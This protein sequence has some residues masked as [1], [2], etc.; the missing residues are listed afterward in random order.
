LENE[1]R[2]LHAIEQVTVGRTISF[3]HT[4]KI[5]SNIGY[6]RSDGVWVTQYDS[7][8]IVMNQE[9]KIIKWQFTKGTSL[10]QVRTI[11]EDLNSL[12]LEQG[13]GIQTVFI[14]DCC[15]LRPKL[16]SIFGHNVEVK[17]D[18]FHAIQRITRTVSK[19]HSLYHQCVLDLR[20][21]F[22]QRGDSGEKRTAETPPP[23]DIN[24]N[25]SEFCRKWE[26][27]CDSE[28]KQIWNTAT[29]SA[30][31]NLQTHVRDGCLSNIQP[32]QGTNRNE[33][34][35]RHLNT[36]FNK[37]KIGILLAYGLMTVLIHAHNSQT[38]KSGK[39]ITYPP[40]SNPSL[41]SHSLGPS[42]PNG[43]VRKHLERNPQDDH[44][45]IDV[46]GQQIDLHLVVSVYSASVKILHITQALKQMSLMQMIKYVHDF[47][48]F[49]LEHQKSA[50]QTPDLHHLEKKLSD[51]G[52][53]LSE[54][55][56]DGNCFFHSVS[57]N[58]LGAPDMWKVAM[59]NQGFIG[60]DSDSLPK[61]LQHRLRKLFVSQ[62]LGGRQHY[63]YR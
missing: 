38:V 14:D 26:E 3:D 7:M 44:W 15:K 25:L 37:S 11:L 46:S 23:D 1:R 50:E 31:E 61:D 13:E 32:G 48:A 33:R 63:Y 47:Q 43:I 9:G 49:S 17:L 8:F 6:S 12:G 56:K 58:I 20:Q 30:V 36:F 52:L 22:R 53:V 35:H 39:R 60:S 59:I 2:Y 45:E 54:S 19:R 51:C 16:R 10:E 18:L 40:F 55:P 34:F 27:M 24:L 5:A 42:R 4:F 57:A 28:G 62:I 41:N 21:V 29:T